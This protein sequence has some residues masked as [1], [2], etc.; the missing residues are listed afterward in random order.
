M[1]KKSFLFLMVLV[2]LANVKAQSWSE[3]KGT[4]SVYLCGEGYGETVQEADQQALADLISQISVE[5]RKNTV[6]TEDEKVSSG[7]YDVESY[8]SSKVQTFSEAT[9][10]NAAKIVI[11]NEF[12]F[13]KLKI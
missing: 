7:N 5:V 9:L 3:V 13:R 1:M 12:K 2:T 10:T 11:T 6:L 4:K 8:F